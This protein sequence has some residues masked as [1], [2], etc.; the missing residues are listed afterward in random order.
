[1]A[2]S[3]IY[4]DTFFPTE[5][6]VRPLAAGK[7]ILVMGPKHFLQRL[8]DQGFQ[9]WA[10]LWDETYDEMEG[11][12]R[13]FMIRTVIDDVRQRRADIIPYLQQHSKHNRTVLSDLVGKHRPG[14]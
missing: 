14:P 2:E 13:L 7:P 4:G 8:K 11:M 5:K 3:Y 12:E 1:V 9:T 10:N 6:T